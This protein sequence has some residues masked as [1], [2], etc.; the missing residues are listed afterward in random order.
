MLPACGRPAKRAG[1][2]LLASFLSVS[3]VA[4]ATTPTGGKAPIAELQKNSESR[5]AVSG[6][7]LFTT[8]NKGK[9]V[10]APA[11]MLVEWPDKLR[12]ELQD[13]V[14]S[15]LGLLVISGDR[16]WLY[17][18]NR[19]ENLTGPLSAMPV[20]V[21]LPFDAKSLVRVFL[22]R[23]DW[24]AFRDAPLGE[25]NLL[26]RP[27]P[28]GTEFVSYDSGLAPKTFGIEA[29]SGARMVVEYDDYTAQAGLRFPTKVRLTNEAINRSVLLVWKDWQASVP[30]EKKLFQ[31][32]QQRDFG[33]PTKALR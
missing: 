26:K 25:G 16:F 4:C 17:Q 13:P 24:Q 33:R 20:E 27:T 18:Q 2:R 14:G 31:I 22:A 21:Q 1:F 23:P 30:Q 11:V 29:K 3:L 32:P 12:L 5:E 10:T 8:T 6:T 28:S 15:V 9:S 7:L 19:K